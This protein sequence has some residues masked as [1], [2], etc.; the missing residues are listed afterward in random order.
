M[1]IVK[2]T[3]CSSFHSKF[4]I[5]CKFCQEAFCK[6]C[7]K[8]NI[9]KGILLS[10]T[11]GVERDYLENFVTDFLNINQKT[12]NSF[13]KEEIKKIPVEKTVQVKFYIKSNKNR[14]QLINQK[15]NNCKKI[16]FKLNG[17]QRTFYQKL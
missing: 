15:I 9:S 17:K 12:I 1:V 14:M 16:N 6:Y 5:S 4:L 3:C 7:Q 11:N 2:K 8:F 10:Q 13:H